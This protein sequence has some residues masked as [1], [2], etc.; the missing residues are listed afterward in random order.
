M[1]YHLGLIAAFLLYLFMGS[2]STASETYPPVEDEMKITILYDNYASVNNT[3][4]EWGFACLIEGKEKTILFDT[5]GKPDV[6]QHNMNVLNIDQKKIDVIIISHEHWD[7]IQGLAS[8]LENNNKVTV[9]LLSSFSDESVN[10]IKATGCDVAL[11]DKPLEICG[12][13]FT[14]GVL[15]TSIKEQSLILTTSTGNVVVTGCAH[16]GIVNIIQRSKEI[17]PGNIKLAMGGFHLR[18]YSAEQM[19]SIIS[20]FEKLGVEKCGASHCTGDEQ[21]KSFR[22]HYKENYIEL[23]AGR[24]LRFEGEK[25]ISN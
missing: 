1:K 17:L 3:K 5:G 16:P 24:I 12:G 14:T 23:G 25:I 10:K 19:A 20:D 15:G 21:I 22:E 18:S 9:Y 13:V 6:L 2:V 7:H 11:N 4:A 8:V